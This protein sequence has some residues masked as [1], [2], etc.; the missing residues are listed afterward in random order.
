MPDGLSAAIAALYQ[1]RG[2]KLIAYTISIGNSERATLYVL[3]SESGKQ[4][5]KP[6]ENVM[7]FASIEWSTDGR[8]FNCRSPR[9]HCPATVT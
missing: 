5:E 8:A 7:S 3:D 1:S 6:I 9:T 2:G 4:V